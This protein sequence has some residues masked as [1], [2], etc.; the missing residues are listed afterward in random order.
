MGG[1][2]GREDNGRR[3]GNTKSIRIISKTTGQKGK[4]ERLSKTERHVPRRKG[5]D[6]RFRASAPRRQKLLARAID[7][8]G[9]DSISYTTSQFL[10][11][12]NKIAYQ[13]KVFPLLLISP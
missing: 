2:Q 6:S 4:L 12:N 1:E 10:T 13:N 8:Q 3:E 11:F 9:G 5:I 7:W